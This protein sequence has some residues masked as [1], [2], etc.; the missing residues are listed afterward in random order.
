LKAAAAGAALACA[1]AWRAAKAQQ[2]PPGAT[3]PTRKLGRTGVSVSLVGVGGAHL[4]RT[5][6][7]AE[8]IHI[9]RE[10]ID[11]GVTFLDNSW[12]YN[13][14]VS[15]ERMGKALK[16]GY[17]GRAFLM[18]K[19]DGRTAAAATGQ[20]EQS[21]RRLGTD[22]IDLVQIH[23]VIRMS[24]PARVFAKGGAIEALVK[25]KQD[26]K[27]R[28][29]GFTG[30][31]S[32]EIHSEMLKTAT[33]HGF[34]FDSV[35]MPLN[36]MDAH[37]DSFEKKV[38]PHLEHT[39]TGIIGMKSLG[40]K[41]ILSSGVVSPIE[42]LQYAMSLPISVLVT[43][44]ESVGILRQAIHAAYTFTPMPPDALAALLART[45]PAAANGR[46]EKYKT[47]DLFDTTAHHPRWLESA[48]M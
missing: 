47:S 33:E 3:M 35:Q 24:D 27:I 21:L 14:G 4:G 25:A 30:H 12:D 45:A 37:Y 43:G 36:V 42:C 38:V 39:R 48:R 5:R 1:S 8:A 17:R 11:H 32:P 19:I 18:T 15:E 20:L 16:D 40:E 29:I 41:I 6:D 28:F 7:E 2:L 46:F 34:V 13:G 9:V 10:A 22:V 26:G 44:C 31:K 23:E